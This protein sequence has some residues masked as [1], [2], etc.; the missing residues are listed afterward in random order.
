M[1]SLFK[2]ELL[3]YIL[4]RKQLISLQFSRKTSVFPFNQ[5][6]SFSKFVLR[7]T[8]MFMH[9][10]FDQETFVCFTSINRQMAGTKE[11]DNLRDK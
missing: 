3:L 11:I 10:L 1:S 4:I 2:Q 7:V 9:I 8:S 5:G 6:L